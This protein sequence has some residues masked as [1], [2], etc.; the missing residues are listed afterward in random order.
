MLFAVQKKRAGITLPLFGLFASVVCLVILFLP[1][2]SELAPRLAEALVV[3][4]AA[5]WLPAW[6]LPAVVAAVWLGPAGFQIATGDGKPISI[7]FFADGVTLAAIGVFVTSLHEYISHLEAYVTGLEN[8][9][10]LLSAKIDDQNGIDAVTG[11]LEE[12]LLAP[13]L[14]AELMRSRR[15]GHSF[16]L[17]KVS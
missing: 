3:S 4:A 7:R 14:E 1:E 5:I 16:A 2:G 8:R 17:V 11:V 13:A 10:R 15:Y 9:G 12:R 6:A